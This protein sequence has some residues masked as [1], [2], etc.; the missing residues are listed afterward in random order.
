MSVVQLGLSE[1]VFG[2]VTILAVA[3]GVAWGV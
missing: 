3:A 2:A 1:I